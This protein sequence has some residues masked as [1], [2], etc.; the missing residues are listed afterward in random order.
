MKAR[1]KISQTPDGCNI[2]GIAASGEYY[3]IHLC[4]EGMLKKRSDL[5]LV[6]QSQIIDAHKDAIK[7]LIRCRR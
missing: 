7:I 4:L 2:A 3:K 1:T 5:P 6:E